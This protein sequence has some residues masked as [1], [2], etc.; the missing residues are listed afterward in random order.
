MQV[1]VNS[2]PVSVEIDSRPHA[3]VYAIDRINTGGNHASI[4]LL[5]LQFV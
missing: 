2:E 3:N 1:V 5:L 4:F